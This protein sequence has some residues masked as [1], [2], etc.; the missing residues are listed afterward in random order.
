MPGSSI[1]KNVVQLALAQ[2]LMMSVNTLLLTSSAI[3]GFELSDIKALATLPL[4]IQFFAT[5]LTTIPAS[6]IMNRLG[7]KQGFTLSS[8]IGLAGSL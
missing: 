7:R 4:A 5:M 6:L 8:I 1:N 3:I 2:A